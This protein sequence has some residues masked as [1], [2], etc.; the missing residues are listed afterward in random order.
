MTKGLTQRIFCRLLHRQEAFV[1]GGLLRN[2]GLMHCGKLRLLS[3]YAG[4]V[5]IHKWWLYRLRSKGLR[6]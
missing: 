6:Y 4:Q 1:H 5:I 3:D 2:V